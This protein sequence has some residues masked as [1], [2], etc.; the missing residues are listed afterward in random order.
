MLRVME[1][2]FMRVTALILITSMGLS[3]P[4]FAGR[5]FKSVLGDVVGTTAKT[6]VMLLFSTSAGAVAAVN[7]AAG[8][9]SFSMVLSIV[10]M[11]LKDQGKSNKQQLAMLK[12]DAYAHTMGSEPSIA[13]Q[14]FFELYR[15]TAREQNSA[16]AQAAT[17]QEIALVIFQWDI[18]SI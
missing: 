11:M 17:T 16:E 6:T 13:L 1:G 18:N 15:E 5:F 2:F 14:E 3:T 7:P 12:D 9:A 4:A 10:S 8:A